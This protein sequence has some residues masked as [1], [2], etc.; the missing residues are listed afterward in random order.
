MIPPVDVA[1]LRTVDE[2]VDSHE[3]YGLRRR[4]VT[5]MGQSRPRMLGL[6]IYSKATLDVVNC[7]GSQMSS[8]RVFRWN[9]LGAPCA[10]NVSRDAMVD[11]A[12]LCSSFG[13]S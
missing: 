5:T 8:L 9:G 12:T 1:K 10:G 2:V 4:E 7:F 11:E 13:L 3:R 6:G